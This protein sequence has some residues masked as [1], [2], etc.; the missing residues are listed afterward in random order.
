MVLRLSVAAALLAALFLGPQDAVARAKG[1]GATA[2]HSSSQKKASKKTDHVGG[3]QRKDGKYV[4][5]YDRRPAGTKPE[6]QSHSHTGSVK[7]SHTG[8]AHSSTAQHDHHGRIHRS[9]QAKDE[10]KREHPCPSTGRSSGA[11]PGYVIDHVIPLKRGGADDHS[12]M[13][14]QTVA[15]A[16]AKDKWE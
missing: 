13:Q 8:S 16:K 10:F 11:C 15:D 9:A 3:Y 12:N 6:K 4:K 2:S 7:Q 1:H 14:W 5:P